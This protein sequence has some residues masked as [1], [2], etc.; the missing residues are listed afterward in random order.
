MLRSRV[1]THPAT[2]L[3]ALASLAAVAP[4]HRADAQSRLD[5]ALH[6]GPR[7]SLGADAVYSAVRAHASDPRIGDGYGFDAHASVGAGALSIAAGYQRTTHDLTGTT[8]HATYS[9]YY[10]EPRVSLFLGGANFAPYVAGRVG[11]TRLIEAASGASLATSLTGTTYGAGGGVD[12]WL[13]RSLALDLGAMWSR[14]DIGSHRT[15]AEE[16]VRDGEDGFLL[17]AGVRLTP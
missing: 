12:V 5:P 4:A 13:A 3:L 11:R 16:V 8:Q 1:R 17:R 14:L 6:G 7:L 9:G 10:A 15:S 2:T